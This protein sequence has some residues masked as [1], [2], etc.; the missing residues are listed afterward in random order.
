MKHWWLKLLG[1]DASTAPEGSTV[2]FFFSCAPRSWTV[3]L[4]LALVAGTIYGVYWLYQREMSTCPPRGRKMLA[5]LRAAVLLV[6]ILLFMGPGLAITLHRA[7]TPHVVLLMDD[8]MSMSIRDGYQNEKLRGQVAAAL[9][10]DGA[11]LASNPPTRAEV[12]D[13]LLARNGNQWLKDLA[14]KGKLRV[15]T[16][17]SSAKVRDA[18][19]AATQ[20][21]TES[22]SPIEALPPLNPAGPGT[23][24]SKGLREALRQVS[25]NPSA[26]VVLVTDGQNTEGDDPLLAAEAARQQGVPVMVLGVGDPDEP[27]NL[28][29]A[30]LLAPDTVFRADPFVIQARLDLTGMSDTQVNV[31]LLRRGN[32]GEKVV[33][34]KSVRIAGG[35]G[36]VAF[37]HTPKD[38]GEY[39]FTVRAPAL[40]GEQILTDNAKSVAIK[41]LSEQAKVLLIAGSPT[42][43]FQMVRTL[44][45]RDKTIDVSCWL[46]SLDEGMRQD[47][48]TPVVKLPSTM[49][50]MLKYDVVILMDPN[51]V[52]F[53]ETRIKLLST[54]VTEHGGGLMWQAGAKYSQRFFSMPST[55][56][57]IDLL[58]VK[59]AGEVGKSE[60]LDTTQTREWPMKVTA[61]GV[62]H[63][64]MRLDPDPLVSRN[65]AQS[66]PG[67]FW[68]YPVQEIKPGTVTLL[69]HTDP[70]LTRNSKGR[71]LL[72]VGQ[73]GGRTIF[74]GVDGTWR[75]RKF[76]EKYFDQFW[77][78]SVRY[79]VEGR[80]LG[81]QHRG[82]LGTDRDTYALGDQI[83]ITAS[84]LRGPD[85][86]LMT[87]PAV[88]ATIKTPAGITPLELR[89][90]SGQA[91]YYEAT[92]VAAHLGTAEI[93]IALLPDASG[94]PARITRQ[95]NI[96]LPRVEF[97][98]PRLNKP[99]LLEIASRSGGQYFDVPQAHELPKVLAD[100]RESVA[101]KGKPIDLWDTN[102][103]LLLLA[104][105]LT[106]EWALRKYYKLL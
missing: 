56:G 64:L 67:V 23:N 69:E 47:G 40:P 15:M 27:R 101:V 22:E 50:E 93:A 35:R 42:W 85:Q 96:E 13:T 7:I 6:L 31:E 63:A 46:Q 60:P 89:S 68:S 102:R 75:W 20:N 10:R 58:P 90:T 54:F 3:F 66:L 8:S 103:M 39:V 71:P 28:R 98:D 55:R 106:A 2:E 84:R 83:A 86:K 99:L 14:G 32:D 74:L 95:I 70:R 25:G 43:D 61:A 11:A 5:V 4:V 80:L 45:I 79:L 26:G 19:G 18:R 49:E 100:R 51:P 77:V 53:D 87:D 104:G 38:A 76:G 9:G 21:A 73:Q 34:T 36:N 65:M 17:S 12:I 44:L 29:V 48:D 78:Q 57:I 59:L 24:I 91:G 62:D 97:A 105:L 1:V 92:A 30:D 37:E 41:V 88:Q 33:A 52:E 94:K 72:T 82:R 16:F 81:S